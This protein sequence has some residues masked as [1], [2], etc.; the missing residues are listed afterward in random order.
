[1]N[2]D[3]RLLQEDQKHPRESLQDRQTESHL[4]DA[5]RDPGEA[6][7]VRVLV[8]GESRMK[9]VLRRHAHA[10]QHYGVVFLRALVCLRPSG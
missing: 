6:Y 5:C 3:E 1:M 2:I 8:V 9:F 4:L 7:V 10:E